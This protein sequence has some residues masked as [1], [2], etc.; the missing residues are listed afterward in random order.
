MSGRKQRSRIGWRWVALGA[1]L[2]LAPGAGTS[3]AQTVLVR[4]APPKSTVELL[5]NATP[6]GSTAVDQAGE[7]TLRVP[8][9]TGKPEMD[10]TIYIDVCGDDAI[11]VLL[12]ERGVQAPA[13]GACARRDVPALFLV[14]P[15]STLVINVGG[16]T[17][18]V[19]LRQGPYDPKVASAERGR[20]Q[21]PRGL[22]LFGGAGLWKVRDFRALA[23][24]TVAQC[25][26]DDITVSYTGGAAV[27]ITSFLGAEAAYLKPTDSTAEGSGQDY[28]FNSFFDTR[29][30][31]ASG[32]LGV[33]LG[34]V[35]L[36]GKA[37]GAYHRG[38]FHTTQTMD[39][40][41]VIVDGVSQTFEGG[42]QT[43]ELRTAGWG[44]LF[45]GGIEAWVARS[46]ALY[47]E[48]SRA[49]LKGPAVE[50]GEGQTNE[51]ITSFLFGARIRIG[52]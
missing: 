13:A 9:G 2:H 39:E 28:R 43:F 50:D 7:A 41:T 30:I 40:I 32:L 21:A 33:P 19:L 44:W 37:G 17:P 18:T 23:C 1:A 6:V 52:R 8:D 36:Y 51:R 4:S 3:T 27:W 47:A 24:G 34:P 38:T 46:F 5:L 31:T 14:R 48:G 11:R 10:A 45:G 12:V 35:R 49:A 25:T 16:P 42:T 26:A 20:T 22:V 29:L 15:V